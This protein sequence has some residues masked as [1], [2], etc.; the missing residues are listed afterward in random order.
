MRR[1]QRRT[2][3]CALAVAALAATRLCAQPALPHP[4]EDCGEIERNY[5]LIKADAVSVQINAILFK[6]ADRGC[7]ALAKK[8]LDAGGSLLARD[9]RGA[10]ALAHAAR[11]GH[12]KLVEFFLAQGAPIDA[13]NVDGATALFAAAAG[14]KHSTVAVLLAKGADPNI[15]GRKGVTPLIAAAF[16]GN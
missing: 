3:A 6:A 13:R 14:E 1:N 10:A 4:D 2:L 11:E 12:V 15:P 16:N 7:E 5:E 9:R 8:L